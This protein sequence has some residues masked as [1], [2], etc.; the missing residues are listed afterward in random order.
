M[1]H[2][3]RA[4]VNMMRTWQGVIYFTSS[5]LGLSSLV[6]AL[7][8]PIKMQKK[9]A[10]LDIFIDIFNVPIFLG[11]SESN[12]TTGDYMLLGGFGKSD[13]L[14]NNYIALL[15][16]AFHHCGAYDALTMLGTTAEEGSQLNRQSKAFLKNI[17]YLSS[18]L[19]PEVPHFP[20]LIHIATDF[21]A[22]DQHSTRTRA[23]K[24]V[25]EL[26]TVALRNPLEF[27]Q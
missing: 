11:G 10:I 27:N 8:Q 12:S 19:L 14:L 1:K 5:K 3:Y 7:N 21:T 17:I 9:I 6:E 22:F 16:Q 2:A 18:N 13:N 15:L 4:I 23:T 26:S 24:L 20:Q 25:K